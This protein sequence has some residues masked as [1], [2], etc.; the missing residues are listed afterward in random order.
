M[1][2]LI[3]KQKHEDDWH[4]TIQAKFYSPNLPSIPILIKL[5]SFIFCYAIIMLYYNNI[6][7]KSGFFPSEL[8]ISNSFTYSALKLILMQLERIPLSLCQIKHAAYFSFPGS[9]LGGKNKFLIAYINCECKIPSVR[10]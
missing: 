4:N 1:L 7:Q 10:P 8:Q 6:L 2:N 5:F 3:L 9:F